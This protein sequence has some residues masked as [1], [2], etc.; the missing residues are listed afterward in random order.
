MPPLEASDPST[1]AQEGDHKWPSCAYTFPKARGPYV[2]AVSYLTA[3]ICALSV[4]SVNSQ[5][6]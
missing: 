5:E 1:Q 4:L 2:A 6:F 3:A